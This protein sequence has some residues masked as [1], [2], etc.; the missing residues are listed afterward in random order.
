MQF[1]QNGIKIGLASTRRN[2]ERN[3]N[4][5]SILYW[6]KLDD[7]HHQSVIIFETEALAK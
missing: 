7:N 3:E 1:I 5:L 2:P 4:I 6:W